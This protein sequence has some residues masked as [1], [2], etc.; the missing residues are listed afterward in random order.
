MDNE[1]AHSY[2]CDSYAI[3]RYISNADKI[4]CIIEV[5]TSRIFLK[6]GKQDDAGEEGLHNRNQ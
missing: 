6:D 3:F 4:F 1:I 5:W 2:D